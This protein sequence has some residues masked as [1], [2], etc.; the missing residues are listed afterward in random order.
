MLE[1]D[2]QADNNLQKVKIGQ[3][4]SLEK[5]KSAQKLSE[6]IEGGFK[7]HSMPTSFKSGQFNSSVHPND[8]DKNKMNIPNKGGG[9]H[10]KVGLVIISVGVLVLAVLGYFVYTYVIFPSSKETKDNPVVADNNKAVEVEKNQEQDNPISD[11]EE[12][13]SEPVEEPV[14]EPVIEPETPTSTEIIEPEP[15]VPATSTEI[16]E[17]EPE[18]PTS[19][20]IAVVSDSDGDGLTDLEEAILNTDPNNPDTDGDGYDDLTEF[21]N[22]YNP[23]GGPALDSVEKITDTYNLVIYDNDIYSYSMLYPEIFEI[24]EMED[25]SS[26]MFM[27]PNNEGFFQVSVE[28]NIENLDIKS[29]YEK[30]FSIEELPSNQY[31]IDDDR[32]LVFSP[33]GMYIYL[34]NKIKQRIF[35]ISYASLG[36]QAAYPNIFSFCADSFVFWTK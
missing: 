10:K 6:N 15:E 4:S 26:V 22:S 17:P 20:P 36:M 14:E 31:Y 1:E 16:I 34:T 2:L 8:L 9:G 28:S 3:L 13:D 23:K 33:D 32:E 35:I 18:V 19:T 30:E 25:K 11:P 27:D 21:V 24:K 5:E 7:I 12:K 29:W